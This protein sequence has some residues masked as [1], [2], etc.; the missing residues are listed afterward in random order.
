M[1]VKDKQWLRA[2]NLRLCVTDKLT[3]LRGIQLVGKSNL[4]VHRQL[5]L[6]FGSAT[7]PLIEVLHVRQIRLT[8]QHA[9]IVIAVDNAAHAA[10]GVM[11]L[12]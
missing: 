8:N 11:H 5:Q 2:M 4:H 12:R 6:I 7:V 9:A 10:H 1:I 3:E